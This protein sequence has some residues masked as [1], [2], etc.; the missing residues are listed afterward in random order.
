MRKGN[1]IIVTFIHIYRKYHISMYFL[2]KIIFYFPSKEKIYFAEKNT[3]F[4]DNTRNIIFQRDFFWQYYLFRAFEENI[5]FP[6]IFWERSSFIFRLKNKAIFSGKINTIFPDIT[7]RKIIFQCYF[8]WKG[9]LLRTFE[10]NTILPC[11]F[12]RKVIFYFSSKEWYFREKGISSF[13]VI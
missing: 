7:A 13:L 2:R 12:L 1:I 4:P 9:H 6:C 8:F 11:I 3:I 10:E 5:V